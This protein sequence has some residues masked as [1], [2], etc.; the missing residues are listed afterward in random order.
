M[1]AWT[2]MM[3]TMTE[4]SL[5]MQQVA[6]DPQHSHWY[7]ERFRKLEREGTD[8][9]GEARLI[10]AMAARGSHILDA[11]CGSGRTGGYLHRAGHRVVGV[12]VDPVLIAAAEEDHPGPRWIVQDLAELDLPAV[13]IDEPF[14]LIVSAGNV[15]AF[16][17][18]STRGT[19][20][21]R[22]RAHLRDDG[23]A[24]IG[25]GAGRGYTFDE[26]L[27]DATRAELKPDLLLS[28]WDVRP[29]TDDS[30]FLVAVLRP[31]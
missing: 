2:A 26:F 8:V 7:V 20:L 22:V 17:A 30:D 24:V 4:P 13:G 5:W 3:A 15:M 29:F 21:S 1:T 9:Y 27:D 14:D 12:D 23:R 19:V 16:L 10:D 31:A 28:T 6:D 18:P 11:G 25:F